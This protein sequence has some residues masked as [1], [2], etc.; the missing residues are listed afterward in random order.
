MGDLSEFPC[1]FPAG[2]A[3]EFVDPERRLSRL[4][5]IVVSRGRFI[6][7][8]IGPLV[9]VGVLYFLTAPPSMRADADVLDS[10]PPR[11]ATGVLT[12]DE[13]RRLAEACRVRAD[14]I[15]PRLSHDCHTLI[16][17]PFV[18]AG[19]MPEAVLRRYVDSV[20][21]PTRR[22][23]ET[24]YFDRKPNEPIVVLVFSND[25][26]FREHATRFDG[27]GRGCYSGY[28]QRNSRRILLNIATGEGTLAHEVTHALAHF[29]FPGMPEW[30]DE[31]LASLHEQC[32]FTTDGLRLDGLRNWRRNI[33]LGEIRAGR[34]GSIEQ[35]MTRGAVRGRME[36][37]CYAHA[38]D[39]CLYLQHRRLLMP[40]YRKFRAM[41][42]KDETGV[43]TLKELLHVDSLADFDREF[44]A[45]VVADARSRA[46]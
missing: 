12:E 37:V 6:L 46:R 34:L 13:Q 24:S 10:L 29:D 38:R 44:R 5:D 1:G 45:W 3:V 27:T 25:R 31:G 16:A 42:S 39:F 43:L 35:L 26:S 20:V 41:A 15:A 8:T 40:F 22:A 14:E 7:L 23:L 32:E 36:S 11:A 21:T 4:R 19:D 28:Y 2:L 33:L 17:P 9:I 30:F 18:V